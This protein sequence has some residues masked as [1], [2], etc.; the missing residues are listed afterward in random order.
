MV[1]I[2]AVISSERVICTND[3]LLRYLARKFAF[4]TADLNFFVEN[5]QNPTTPVSHV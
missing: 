1:P 5:S 4:A 3:C 2:K